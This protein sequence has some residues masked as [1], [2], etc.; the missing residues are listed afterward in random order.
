MQIFKTLAGFIFH[1]TANII[2]SRRSATT[3]FLTQQYHASRS[4]NAGSDA[5]RAPVRRHASQTA[6][7]TRAID[8]TALYYESNC[9]RAWAL[10]IE[11]DFHSLQPRYAGASDVGRAH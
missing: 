2:I 7:Q 4:A 3:A 11:V 10:R 5:T 8:N 9:S 1:L 6:R